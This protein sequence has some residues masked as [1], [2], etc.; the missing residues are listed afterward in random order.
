MWLAESDIIAS[1]VGKLDR[2]STTS[3]DSCILAEVPQGRWWYFESLLVVAR[4]LWSPASFAPKGHVYMAQH[5][6]LELH[7]LLCGRRSTPTWDGNFSV[8]AARRCRRTGETRTTFS[9]RSCGLVCRLVQVAKAVELPE[10]VEDFK[11][12]QLAGARCST[13]RGCGTGHLFLPRN[14]HLDSS[15]VFGSC[16]I[17]WSRTQSCTHKDGTETG[18]RKIKDP[19]HVTRLVS[20]VL[21]RRILLA[22][23]TNVS[24]RWFARLGGSPWSNVLPNMTCMLGLHAGVSTKLSSSCC[25]VHLTKGRTQNYL[26]NRSRWKRTRGLSLSFVPRRPRVLAAHLPL[27]EEIKGLLCQTLFTM[28]QLTTAG[29][30]GLYVTTEEGKPIC[31]HWRKVAREVPCCRVQLAWS[32]C[33]S[34]VVNITRTALATQK[35]KF[36][37]RIP[38]CSRC[39]SAL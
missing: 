13:R 31:L 23:A 21:E 27:R 28:L 11:H 39:H 26:S 8:F 29:S 16:A 4:P 24:G 33:A 37:C 25:V 35:R 34:T 10:T 17:N 1:L 38:R 19:L 15:C 12:C 3:L 5:V 32:M 30:K 7:V 20:P 18:T 9:N 22:H 2:Y 36:D 6:V 14:H